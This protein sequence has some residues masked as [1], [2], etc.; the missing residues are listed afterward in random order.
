MVAAGEAAPCSTPG[1][2]FSGVLDVATEW[3]ELGEVEPSVVGESQLEL[4][5]GISLSSGN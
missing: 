1:D 4:I 3:N 2:L 5:S